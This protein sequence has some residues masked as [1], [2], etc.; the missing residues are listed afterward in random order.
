MFSGSIFPLYSAAALQRIVLISV[1]F[2]GQV[3]YKIILKRSLCAF[4]IGEECNDWIN[5]DV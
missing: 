1:S 5:P 2:E 4:S 3:K